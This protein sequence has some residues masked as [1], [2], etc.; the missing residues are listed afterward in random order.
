MTRIIGGIL[1]LMPNVLAMAA[2]RSG[3]EKLA[4]P[5]EQY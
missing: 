2:E 5:A 3:Q 4:T 1:I